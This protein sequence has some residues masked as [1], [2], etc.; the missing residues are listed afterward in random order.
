MDSALNSKSIT[1]GKPPPLF[2]T[3]QSPQTNLR[4]IKKFG[5]SE[6]KKSPKYTLEAMP[7][8]P[9]RLTD[10]AYREQV[11]YYYKADQISTNLTSRTKSSHQRS[12]SDKKSS[13]PEE[14]R[15]CLPSTARVLQEEE[16]NEEHKLR[17]VES[18]ISSQEPSCED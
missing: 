1:S 15:N 18:T 6:D 8:S 7:S 10:Q 13:C 17:S 5:S 11:L 9:K 3:E 14:E 16:N 4:L 2:S 12:W